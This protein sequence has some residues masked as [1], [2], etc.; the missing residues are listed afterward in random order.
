MTGE[1]LTMVERDVLAWP[2]VTRAPGRFGGIAYMVGRRE[3]GHVHP[4]S[5]ADFGFPRAVREELIQ[6]GRAIPHHALPNSRTAASY[7]IRDRA[8]VAGAVAL[9]RLNY[10]RATGGASGDGSRATAGDAARSGDAA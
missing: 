5:L 10:E 9:F 1:L 6:S 8:D 2:G 3:I 7:W 4:P